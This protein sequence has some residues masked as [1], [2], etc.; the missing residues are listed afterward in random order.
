M[1]NDASIRASFLH[2]YLSNERATGLA[3]AAATL[4]FVL[5]A[6]RTEHIAFVTLAVIQPVLHALR[7]A[8]L[9]RPYRAEIARIGKGTMSSL[10]ISH[11]ERAITL[12]G[13]A[14]FATIAIG[15]V[16]AFTATDDE[17][18]RVLCLCL[19]LANALGIVGRSFAVRRLVAVQIAALCV[20][21]SVAMLLSD[22]P[23]LWS[24]ALFSVPFA[25]VTWDLTVRLRADLVGVVR[26]REVAQRTAARFS[27][28]LESIPDLVV[29]LG[30]GGHARVANAAA[31]RLMPELG[32]QRTT[33]QDAVRANSLFAPADVRRLEMHVANASARP[34]SETYKTGDG[35]ILDVSVIREET[36]DT[37]IIMSDVTERE[38]A[39][40]ATVAMARE[41]HLT[42]LMS[43]GWFMETAAEMIEA[44]DGGA[45]PT[46]AVFDLD[47]FKTLN[48]TMGH[49]AGD[50]ALRVFASLLAGMCGD[51]TIATRH[52]GDEFAVLTVGDAPHAEAFRIEIASVVVEFG[53]RFLESAVRLT[54]SAGVSEEGGSIDQ[55]LATADL[56][57]YDAK[58]ATR[59]GEAGA[60]RIYDDTLRE[61]TERR[62]RMK[63]LLSQA[64]ETGHGFDLVYQPIVDPL[65]AKVVCAE[66]LCRW[67]PP[68]L[69][70]VPPPVFIGLAEELGLIRRLTDMIL[71]RA[72]AECASWPGELAVSVNLSAIDI[73][74]P[75][76]V[77][78]IRRPL[79]ATGLAPRRLQLEV[80]ETRAVRNDAATRATLEAIAS[81]GVA[82]ALDDFGTGFS[83]LAT[84]GSLPLRTLKIDRS[85]VSTIAENRCF[86]LLSGAIAMFARMGFRI[87]VEGIETEDQLDRLA[88]VGHPTLVQGY[89]FGRPMPSEQLVAL[90]TQGVARQDRS[91]A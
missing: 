59:S 64:V 36:A 74:S 43:R 35:R 78:R 45:R 68:E 4:G 65:T 27:A 32:K 8:Y 41:D 38:R 47:G 29:H 44:C 37:L 77:D 9:H 42:G 21:V 88:T 11:W 62:E 73:Q 1:A 63:R 80:T 76:L 28:T 72:C 75:D 70:P 81:M 12:F 22:E 34:V 48:D 2:A 79:N 3:A 53:K 5:C 26:E 39:L 56:A 91:A 82:L 58:A 83:N 15:C 17:F 40:A 50:A 16:F 57:L 61:R 69:G 25:V 84:V 60:I 33:F 14:L 19:T 13:G 23:W 24:I 67:S 49:R 71:T 20:P 90:A 6:W 86:L 89:L 46:L 54:A 52:G 85:L 7:I 55:L 30:P 31:V 10:R 87:V 51:R 66:A 18:T